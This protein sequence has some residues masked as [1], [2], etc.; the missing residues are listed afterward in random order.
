VSVCK[1]TAS[2]EPC[3][4]LL[5]SMMVSDARWNG[6]IIDNNNNKKQVAAGSS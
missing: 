3:D 4:R 5:L 6:N 1:G 2:F